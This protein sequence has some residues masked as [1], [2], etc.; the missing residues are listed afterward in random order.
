VIGK[1]RSTQIT[2]EAFSGTQVGPRPIKALVLGVYGWGSKRGHSFSLGL[3]TTTVQ[4][5]MYAIKA[6]IMENIESGYTGRNTY[7]LSD[8]QTEIKALNSFQ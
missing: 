5:E 7:I 1:R 3:H 6:C 8:S 2:K 4:A